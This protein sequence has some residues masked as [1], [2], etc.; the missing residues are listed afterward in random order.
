MKIKIA[1]FFNFLVIAL[2]QKPKNPILK[3]N[4]ID[5]KRSNLIR[6]G[7]SLNHLSNIGTNLV[8]GSNDG[9]HGSDRGI[10]FT[11]FHSTHGWILIVYY[12]HINTL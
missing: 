8:I 2:T 12:T 6:N 7:F 4:Y 9:L 10:H 5:S 3:E 11:A 1:S